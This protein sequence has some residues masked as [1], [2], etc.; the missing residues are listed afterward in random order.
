MKTINSL[1]ART[2]LSRLL[3]DVEQNNE[4]IVIRRRNRPIAR[5][6][7]YSP[8]E[9]KKVSTLDIMSEFSDIRKMQPTGS[10]PVKKLVTQSRKR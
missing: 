3:R 6:V 9:G 7:P 5:L 1:E 8:N 2:H 4:E 10:T